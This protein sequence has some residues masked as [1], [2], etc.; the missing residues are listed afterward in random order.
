MK[1]EGA[2]MLR[3]KRIITIHLLMRMKKPKLSR[4]ESKEEGQEKL[5]LFR[6]KKPLR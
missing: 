6:R 5:R 2:R 4:Q 1:S 3:R